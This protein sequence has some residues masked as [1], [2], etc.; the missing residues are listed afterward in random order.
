MNQLLSL[1]DSTIV[2]RIG[3]VLVHSLWQIAIVAIAVAAVNLLLGRQRVNVRYLVFCGGMLACIG[4]SIATFATLELDR[5]LTASSDN[6]SANEASAV[7]ETVDNSLRGASVSVTDST[8]IA[9]DAPMSS[10][11]TAAVERVLLAD[12]KPAARS[13]SSDSGLGNAAE[14]DHAAIIRP[15]FKTAALVLDSWLPTIFS[16]WIIGVIVLAIRPVIG[17]FFNRRVR[18]HGRSSVPQNVSR[19]M[20][21]ACRQLRLSD[22]IEIA[23]ST[24]VEIPGIIG[25]FKPLVLLPASAVTG[26]SET[27]L[28]AILLHELAHIR[29][30]DYL[31]NLLQTVIESLLFYHPLVWWMSSQIRIERENCCDDIVLQHCD[32]SSEYVRA[33]LLLESHQRHSPVLALNATGGSLVKRV[34]RIARKQT[35][36]AA[37]AWGAGFIVLALIAL[38]P[39]SQSSTWAIQPAPQ[40]DKS[41]SGDNATTD[42]R[43]IKVHLVDDTENPVA[44]AFVEQ[45]IGDKKVSVRTDEAGVAEFALPDKP[46]ELLSIHVRGDF[47]PLK[48]EWDNT[49]DSDPNPIPTSFTFYA[50]RGR[51]LSGRITDAAGNPIAGAKLTPPEYNNWG[52][53]I[54]KQSSQQQTDWTG[55]ESQTDQDGLWSI[56]HAPLQLGKFDAMVSHPDFANDYIMFNAAT[57]KSHSFIMQTGVTVHGAITDPTGRTLANTQVMLTPKFATPGLWMTRTNDRGEYE[58]HHVK[59]DEFGLSVMHKDFTPQTEKIRDFSGAQVVNFQLQPGTPIRFHFVDENDKPVP[60]VR[61]ICNHWR[62]GRALKEFENV[63]PEMSDADGNWVWEHAPKGRVGYEVTR[64][65]SISR[66]SLWLEPKEEPCEY[67]IHPALEISGKVTSKSTGKPIPDFR[68]VRGNWSSGDGFNSSEDSSDSDQDGGI[69]WDQYNA[70]LMKNGHYYFRINE[71]QNKHF[72]KVEAPGYKPAVSDAFFDSDGKFQLDFQLEEGNDLTGKIVDQEGKTVSNAKVCCL[73]PGRQTEIRNLVPEE[74]GL[75]SSVSDADGNFVLPEQDQSYAIMVIA[76]K[77]FALV[78]EDEFALARQKIKIEAWATIR[79]TCMIGDKPAVGEKMMIF[80]ER[81]KELPKSL[82]TSFMFNDI[83]VGNDGSYEIPRVPPN[84]TWT[85]GRA[86]FIERKYGGAMGAA[87][88]ASRITTKPGIVEKVHVG[89]TGR[90]LIGK[91][92]LPADAARKVDDWNDSPSY[93]RRIRGD[94]MY[95][96]GMYWFRINDDGTFRVEDLEAGDYRLLVTAVDMLANAANF[97]IGRVEVDFTIPKIEGGRSDVPFDLGTMELKLK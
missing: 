76:D 49:N 51:K 37:N 20:A 66:R 84:I 35:S 46:P 24:L 38:I 28:R 1:L 89:G 80:P 25:Y 33:L 85:I 18:Y 13:E 27:Q 12:D 5:P 32:N 53:S 81:S 17:I 62:E 94:G 8:L 95:A 96:D 79:G 29:R 14:V 3:W 75:V 92:K 83:V 2:E 9:A 45:R 65:N 63:I 68:I 44:N 77:G 36:G 54:P 82:N 90:P 71:T 50:Q 69:A 61:V 21:E 70:K 52:T 64:K 91:F 97:E 47:V 87:T 58:F 11:P 41:K 23:Q 26:L 30:H 60:G 72:I 43:I 6:L 73:L 39:I 78:L 34:R 7:T 67:V 16:L 86:V 15:I 57:V 88:H 42:S 48:V 31:V 74:Y 22:A 55:W 40:T 10:I 4:I 93:L 59:P 56:N 19:L